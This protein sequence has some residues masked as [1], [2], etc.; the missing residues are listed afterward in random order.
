[1]FVHV[2]GPFPPGDWND[3]MIFRFGVKPLLKDGERVEAD[4]GYAANDPC[5]VKATSKPRFME[6]KNWT[7]VRGKARRRHETI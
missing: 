7:K 2:T 4:D 6:D 1:M 3:L 5:T